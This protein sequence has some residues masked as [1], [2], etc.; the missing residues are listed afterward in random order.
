MSRHETMVRLR[1]MLDHAREAVAMAAGKRRSDLDTDRKL[2]LA[3]VRL[4]EVVGEA[5]A[6]RLRMSAFRILRFHGHR[7]SGYEI[8]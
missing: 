4:L 1:H 2:N 6:G 5:R 7:S 3:L 8:G